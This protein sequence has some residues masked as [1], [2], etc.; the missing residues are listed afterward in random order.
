MTT[1]YILPIDFKFY[2]PEDG[3][4]AGRIRCEY[5]GELFRKLVDMGY[6]WESPWHI[7]RQRSAYLNWMHLSDKLRALLSQ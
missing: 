4:F 6:S 3:A 2:S 5:Q 1:A 7:P